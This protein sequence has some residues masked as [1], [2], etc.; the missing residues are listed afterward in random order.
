MMKKVTSRK[1]GL[2][3]SSKFKVLNDMVAIK[4]Q[5]VDFEVDKPSGLTQ[6]VVNM[7]RQGKLIIPDIAEFYAKKYPCTGHI[8]A[9]GAKCKNELKVGM[10]VL[11]ARH[12]GLR[13]KVDGNDYIFLREIDVHAILD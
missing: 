13:E 12:G 6:D 8:L 1:A 5:P 10:R 2:K 7:V 3:V 11:F 9:L 4:E